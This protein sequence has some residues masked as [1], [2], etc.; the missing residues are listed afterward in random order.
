MM[1][2]DEMWTLFTF[3]LVKFYL[4]FS[5]SLLIF[6]E[7]LHLQRMFCPLVMWN[8]SWGGIMAQ[9]PSLSPD[10]SRVVNLNPT[11]TVCWS[12]FIWVGLCRYHCTDQ[13]YAIKLVGD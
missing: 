1:F 7:H 13:R 5:M 2:V 11:P 8:S 12:L 3:P 9:W 10:T 4:C 6:G